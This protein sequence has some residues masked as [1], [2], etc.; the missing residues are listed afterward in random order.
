MEMPYETKQQLHELE[1]RIDEINK[2]HLDQA[3]LEAKP[4][5]ETVIR[6]HNMYPSPILM[7]QD[8][9]NSLNARKTK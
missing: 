9:I 1:R 2:R 5:M 3:R 7:T 8:M 6:I 4:L